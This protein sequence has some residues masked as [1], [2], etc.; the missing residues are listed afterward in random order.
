MA[1]PSAVM[2]HVG[3]R[4]LPIFVPPGR[5]ESFASYVARLAWA[6]GQPVRVMLAAAGL[7]RDLSYESLP[8]AYGVAL[9]C[10]RRSRF[11]AAVGLSEDEVSAMLLS[12]F[13]GV[14]L[15]IDQPAG[16]GRGWL[17]TLAVR[18]WVYVTGAHCCPKCLADAD[19]TGTS[20]AW[21]LEWKLP[22][23]FA[24]TRHRL[25]LRDHCSSC[26]QRLTV[27]ALTPDSPDVL[28]VI[29]QV[30]AFGF[31]RLDRQAI[32]GAT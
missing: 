8:Y 26:G 12:H 32:V 19:D 11:A 23:S 24:C 20:S 27:P 18:E 28:M 6:Y 9:S 14:A 10:E 17:R 29:P 1:L 31:R 30:R 4:R 13:D 22:W 21:K 16:S 3:Q 2:P 25:L 7:M 15:D 5:S